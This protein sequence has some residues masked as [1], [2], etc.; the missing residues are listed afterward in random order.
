MKTIKH[1]T[2]NTIYKT[3]GTQEPASPWNGKHYE[4]KELQAI[5]GGYIQ[6][7][8]LTDGSVMVMNKEG[9]LEGLPVNVR[10]TEIF[11]K[12][13]PTNPDLIVGDVLV[14]ESKFLK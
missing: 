12:N 11:R 5:I 1:L 7:V 4:L 3:N 10:A 6:Q 9:K 8:Y 14:T 2:M 13:F